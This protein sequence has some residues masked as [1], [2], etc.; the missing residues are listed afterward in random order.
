[1]NTFRTERR[2]QRQQQ[3]TPANTTQQVAEVNRPNQPVP[4]QEPL[5]TPTPPQPATPLIATNTHPSAAS[6]PVND[7][8]EEELLLEPPTPTLLEQEVF[9][10]DTGHAADWTPNVVPPLNIPTPVEEATPTEAAEE[11]EPE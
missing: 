7:D 3:E 1:M 8:D 9:S 2:E 4:F 11:E 10:N 6:I 5:F